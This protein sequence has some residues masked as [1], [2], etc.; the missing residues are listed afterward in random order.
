[1]LPNCLA[2]WTSSCGVSVLAKLKL[3]PLSTSCCIFQNNTHFNIFTRFLIHHLNTLS[4]KITC[5]IIYVLISFAPFHTCTIVANLPR[6]FFRDRK[7]HP[8]D[9]SLFLVQEVPGWKILQVMRRLSMRSKEEI[10]CICFLVSMY[11][12]P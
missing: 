10:L 1:M 4:L 2:T 9:H 12:Y 3:M 7:P 5:T 8:L 11:I 6:K